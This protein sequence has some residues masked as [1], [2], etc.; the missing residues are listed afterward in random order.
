[1]SDMTRIHNFTLTDQ[2]VRD[3]LMAI[4][5]A[6]NELCCGPGFPEAN[7]ISD[8]WEKLAVALDSRLPNLPE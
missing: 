5:D 6:T 7:A 2:D 1:V 8:R 3:L 4:E